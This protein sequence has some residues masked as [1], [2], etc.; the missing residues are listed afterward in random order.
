MLAAGRSHWPFAIALAAGLALRVLA[1]IAYHPALIYIDSIKYL[2]NAYPGAD[3]VGYKVPLRAILAVGN[4]GTVTAGQHLLGLAIAVT[5]Y[6]VLVRRGAGRWLATLATLPVLLD[7]YQIQ[8]EQTI[9]PDVWFEALIVAALAVLL[10]PSVGPALPGADPDR[11]PA[12]NTEPD[13]TAAD[14]TGLDRTAPGWRRL[15]RGLVPVLVAGLLLGASATVR[16]VGEILL[17]PALLYLVVVW[18]GWQMVLTRVIAMTAAFAVPVA[19]YMAGSYLISGHFWLASS[20]PSVSSYGRMAA[21]ADC[22]TLRIPRIERP[23][24]PDARQRAYGIDWLDHDA[25]SPLKSYHPPG[26]ANRYLL[27]SSFDRQV[28]VQQ[29]GRV[30]AAVG[31]DGLKLFALTRTSGQGGTPISRWQFQTFWPAYGSW[32]MLGP[33]QRIVLGLRLSP[34]SPAITRHV[35]DSS[36]GGPASVNEPVAAF[37]RSYQLHGGYTPGPLMALF[38][39]A[40]LA[41]SLLGLARRPARRRRLTQACLAFFATGAA[42]LAMS[43]A[44]Q[45]S[46]RYQLPA[47]VTLPPAGALGLALL[48]SYLRREQ[49]PGG[50][51]ARQDAP[52]LASPAL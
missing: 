4:L 44:F 24:C 33:R 35:L 10:A 18:G 48:L 17:L 51:A 8:I 12:G 31:A 32:V 52:E 39:I 9:M 21:A 22:G 46:W 20:T 49:R 43:D 29:P 1:Q 23:L 15:A 26:G 7:A 38:A 30:L 19:G 2:Y 37:L 42:V 11:T 34:G 40:G 6:V 16:Q 5:L 50:S 36:Y 3:P 28:L 47:L 13:R 45:F 27:V 25:A 41:G 14:R